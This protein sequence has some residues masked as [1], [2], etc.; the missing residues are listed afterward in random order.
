MYYT[1]TF[2][3]NQPR[4]FDT[5][6]DLLTPMQ[7]SSLGRLEISVEQYDAWADISSIRWSKCLS[8]E[9]VGQLTG[10]YYLRL[11]LNSW[12][13]IYPAYKKTASSFWMPDSAEVLWDTLVNFQELP[14]E[15]VSV[16]LN[17]HGVE[18]VMM[19]MIEESIE[20]V[21]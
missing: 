14:L 8:L 21:R 19:P 1:K 10:L 3:F 6:M 13:L 15:E 12:F 16:G 2:S 11:K 18:T 7:K 4:H 9:R 5:F 20:Y 17:S